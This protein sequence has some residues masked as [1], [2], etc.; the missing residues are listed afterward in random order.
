MFQIRHSR[1]DQVIHS[2]IHAL[3]SVLDH[4]RT[5]LAGA[6]FFSFPL[7][8]TP[9]LTVVWTRYGPIEE[10]LETLGRLCGRVRVVLYSPSQTNPSIQPMHTA[11][12]EYLPLPTTAT[13]I[14]SR[15]H[16]QLADAF[17]SS[18]PRTVT[19]MLAYILTITSKDYF[20]KL[21]G[22]VG[23][24]NAT[25]QSPD[26]R[27]RGGDG[28]GLSAADDDAEEQDD[29]FYEDQTAEEAYP[30]FIQAALSD[31]FPRAKRSLRLLREARPDHPLLRGPSD[32]S[33]YPDICWFW[34]EAEVA[35]AWTGRRGAPQLVNPL[36]NHS[37]RSSTGESPAPGPEYKEDLKEFAFFDLTPGQRL[38]LLETT[39]AQSEV[40]ADPQSFMDT[41]PSSL[42]SLTP[43]L[44]HLTALVLS[45]LTQH[46]EA[47]SGA[48]VALFLSPTDVNLPLHL[49]ILRSYLLLTSHAFKSRLTA[50]LF[51]DSD[52]FPDA[53]A[54]SSAHRRSSE[55]GEPLAAS[56]WAVGLSP[57]LTVANIWPPSVPELSFRLRTVVNDSLQSSLGPSSEHSTHAIP[58]DSVIH[59]A[60]YRLGFAIRDLP[61]G[62]GKERWLDPL[63]ES[64]ASRSPKVS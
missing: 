42:P 28:L 41:F 26:M 36:A 23:Y 21:G 25:T 11:P 48:L 31:A 3:S 44:S 50:A 30:N 20:Y 46:M 15:I 43:T 24:N 33:K 53:M 16:E 8:D 49:S 59:D 51:S 32:G 35:A 6:A 18:I 19:A 47:L 40:T 22:S 1:A 64:H 58:Q 2:F 55:A 14:L 9:G 52:D 63:C 17:E 45:P 12:S 7:T 29:T 39:T 5:Q 56:R 38:G 57:A 10:L 13:D 62:P 61:T 4:L 54:K 34:T 60:E 27:T 37:H